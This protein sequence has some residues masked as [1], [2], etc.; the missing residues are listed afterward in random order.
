MIVTI[1]SECSGLHIVDVTGAKHVRCT[2]PTHFSNIII[3]YIDKSMI[4]L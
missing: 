4:K 1:K 2:G 3:E